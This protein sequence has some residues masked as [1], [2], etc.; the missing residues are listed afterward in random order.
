MSRHL[1]LTAAALAVAL[2][3]A[4]GAFALDP[5]HEYDA[6][7][8]N[9][10]NC[11]IPHHAPGGT[12]TRVAGNPNLCMSCHT[13]GGLAANRPFSDNDMAFPGLSGTSHRFD[14]GPSGHVEAALTNSSP[15]TV[16][17]G[18][19]FTGRI[20]KVYTITVDSSGNSG[21]AAFSWSDGVGGSGSGVS[22]TDMA[23]AEGLTL[24]FTDA[25]TSPSFVADDT[26]TLYVRTDLR[27]PDPDDPFES[28]MERRVADGK[29]VCSTCHNQHSQE[30]TPAD[31]NAPAY[32]GDGTGWGRHYQRV[33]NDANQMCHVCHSARDVTSSTQGSHPVGIPVPGTGDFQSPPDLG[34]VQGNV[35][36]TVCHSP[37]FTDSGGANGGAGDGYILRRHIGEICYQC[38]TLADQATASHLNT[39]SGALWPGGQYG[40]AFP[41]H[42]TD[43]QGFCVNCHWPHGWPDDQDMPSDFPKLWVERYDTSDA[44]TDPDDAEDLCYTCHDSD[45]ASTNIRGEFLKGTNG[46]DIFHHPVMDSEQTA[47]RSVECVDCHNPH[48]ATSANK[49]KGVD[50]IDL[51]G[52]PIGPGTANAVEIVQYELCFKC[53]GDTYNSSRPDRTNKRLDFQT[54][55]SAFHPVAGPGRNQSQNMNDQLLGG[56]TSNSTILCTDCHNSDGTDNVTGPA[57]N[58]NYATQGPHGSNNAAILRGEY[59]TDLMGPSNWNSSNFDLCFRCHDTDL[60][61]AR[62]RRDGARTNFFADGENLHWVHLEDRTD[63][64]RA[65][66][67]NCHFNLHSNRTASNTQ[68]NIDGN[69]TDSPPDGVHTHLVNFSPDINAT[70][71]RNKPEWRY[72]TGTR[73][74]SCYLSCHGTTMSESYRPGSSVDDDPF[75]P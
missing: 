51:A 34:L 33:D 70:G 36:C 74:R 32:G 35:D 46:T 67:K 27:L 75:I 42:D 23:V 12:I 41:T 7:G 47:G 30:L 60:V 54:T 5:P 38:H 8:I 48:K 31:P 71:S 13:A 17:S 40:S 28:G 21:A 22:G 43:M 72:N 44:R 3:M 10:S 18:G 6:N 26:F 57:A 19:A 1:S 55:N 53:H 63:K 20:E 68:Y 49:H 11:H 62:E 9:C 16:R 15:G 73:T 61:T 24:T 52:D 59:W 2:A 69:V 37:H 64:A 65:T 39:G 29:V 14:S 50:G 56:L 25:E 58:S 4:P 66:C 45:P